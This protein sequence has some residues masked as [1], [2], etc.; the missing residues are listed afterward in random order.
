MDDKAVHRM[1]HRSLWELGRNA[2][3]S[4]P[5]AAAD[6]GRNDKVEVEMAD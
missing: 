6:S 2:G 4:T 5:S 3:F 1:G